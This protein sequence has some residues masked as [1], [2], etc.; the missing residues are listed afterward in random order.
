M[1]FSFKA[2]INKLFC[3]YCAIS[4][5]QALILLEKWKSETQGPSFASTAA[6]SLSVIIQGA[7]LA[8]LAT[9]R[10]LAQNKRVKVTVLEKTSSEGWKDAVRGGH[11]GLWTDAMCVLRDQDAGSFQELLRG[12]NCGFVH[13]SGY[14][15]TNGEWLIKPLRG[16]SAFDSKTA[17]LGFFSNRALLQALSRDKNVKIAF[18]EGVES[19]SPDCSAVVT[20]SGKELTADLVIAADGSHSPLMKVVEMQRELKVEGERLVDR[21]YN[22]Y[23]GTVCKRRAKANVSLD[24]LSSS[25]Q[26]WGPGA[27]FAVVPSSDGGYSWFA[28]IIEPSLPLGPS[29]QR[30][31]GPLVNSKRAASVGEIT[32]LKA[33]LSGWHSPVPELVSASLEAAHEREGGSC[34]KSDKKRAKGR[35]TLAGPSSVALEEQVTMCRAVASKGLLPRQLL[36]RSL[37]GRGAAITAVG[38]AYYTFDPILAVGGGQAIVAGELLAKSLFEHEGDLDAGLAAYELTYNKRISTLS[39]ISD[40]AQKIGSI[41]SPVLSAYRDVILT[42]LLP[43]A[44]KARAMDVLIGITAGTK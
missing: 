44:A 42:W 19:F 5:G 4:D 26:T 38:D 23:R 2:Q 1:L 11:T 24:R 21:G 20:T 41:Q 12:I 31:D 14:R 7:S 37:R 13:D 25:F 17:S 10:S 40:I 15:N 6:M 27:R 28:A 43:E 22:V 36:G 32:N 9:A 16:V 18:G 33:L 34:G 39:A 30:V 29:E 8:G 35:K 3:F